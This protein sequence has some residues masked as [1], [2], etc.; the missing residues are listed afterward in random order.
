VCRRNV[1]SKVSEMFENLRR[2]CKFG[3]DYQFWTGDEFKSRIDLVNDLVRRY[4]PSY[5]QY[6]QSVKAER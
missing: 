5:W 4:F 1:S 3:Y 6:L 2:N